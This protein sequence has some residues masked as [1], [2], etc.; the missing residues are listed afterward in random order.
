MKANLR[1]GLA[2]HNGYSANESTNMFSVTSG[3]RAPRDCEDG[4]DTGWDEA[5][6]L[7][8]SHVSSSGLGN[9]EWEWMLG[10]VPCLDSQQ[11]TLNRWFGGL[12]PI[13][14]TLPNMR[15]PVDRGVQPKTACRDD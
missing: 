13:A 4:I 5:K 10:D 9:I 6:E 3:L 2:D 14:R 8:S 1:S 7:A 11:A 15:H 12:T